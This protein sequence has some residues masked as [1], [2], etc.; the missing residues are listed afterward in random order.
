MTRDI[1]RE[2]YPF[3]SRELALREGRMHYV[4]E[5]SGDPVVLVHGTPTWSFEWRHVIAA[6]A[7]RRRVIA[8]D[9]LGFGLSERPADVPYTPEW[10]AK[11]FDEFITKLNPAPFT[12]VVHDFGGPIALGFAER[13]P[14][15]VK[16]V[17]IVNSWM[18]SFADDKEMAG[19]AKI[20]GGAF[21][22]W[23]YE[24]MN[25]SLRVIAPSAWGDKRKLTP[26][27]QKQYLDRFPDRWSRGAVL[28]ALARS[29]LGSSAHYESL[30]Q[31]RR[32]LA[33][34]PMTIVWGMKDSAFKPYQLAKWREAFPKA[35][36]VEVAGAGHWPHEEEP[37]AVVAAIASR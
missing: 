5:G 18:W 12:L 29:L 1:D 28:W 36:V 26:A 7:P 8:M 13:N 21:G 31:N 20:A 23:L 24:W 27:I 33:D 37:D 9:H 25:F 10:H 34:R 30:W 11:N 35:Q 19:R 14:E 6:L 15:L 3:R 2:V 16:R 4:D 32:T 17:V 22:K